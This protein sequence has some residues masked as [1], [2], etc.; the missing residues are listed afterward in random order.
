MEKSI[1]RDDYQRIPRPVGALA[2]EFPQG[3]V[4]KKHRHI[5]AQLLYAVTGV[6]EVAT[7][8]GHWIIPPQ[9]ALWIPPDTDHEVRFKTA[10][11]VRTLYVR[12]DAFPPEAPDFPC[13]VRVSPLLRELILRAVAM[14]M[15]YHENGRDGRIVALA[16][17]EIVW[18]PDPPLHLAL[19]RD[20]R[21]ARIYRALL[22]NPADHRT[23]E[24][25]AA[26]AGISSRTLA[27]LSCAEFGLPFSH[28]RQHI[29]VL[30]SLPLLAAG[31]S[32]TAVAL[33]LGYE[34]PGAFTAMFRRLMGKTPSR[35][36]EN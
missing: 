5:R 16:L 35:Y 21:L 27:R 31:Q 10:A 2:K 24:E 3:F 18:T 14:P 29:R 25:W 26:R 9:R 28:W 7:A 6:L 34:T 15:D 8:R 13:A 17:E 20:K 36:F 4:S 1:N 12:P 22:A 19:P 30:A 11:S 23:M 32:V 33:D